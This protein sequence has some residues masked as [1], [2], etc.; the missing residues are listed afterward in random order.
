[1]QDTSTHRAA[2]LVKLHD[3]SSQE[4]DLMSESFTI[5]RK[6][7]NDLP[8]DDPAVSGHHARITKIHAVHFIE[9]LKSTNGT[10]VNDKRIDRHQLRDTDVVTIGRHRIIFRDG[11]SAPA[12]TAP[13]PAG[14]DLDRTMVLTGQA[15]RTEVV[16]S[17][18]SLRVLS[19]NTDQQE[20]LLVKQVTAIGSHAQAAVKLT[21]WFAPSSAAMITR[22]LNTYYVCQARNGKRIL[23]NGQAVTGEKELKDK[24]RIEVAGATLLFR[25]KSEPKG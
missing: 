14:E 9:D 18:A 25:A 21:G 10:F 11:S 8:I 20:Y 5:G 4:I 15:S 7:D 12:T 24:D 2:L 22:R 16:T 19:G 13:A 17:P 6:P 23:V 1:M 3:R